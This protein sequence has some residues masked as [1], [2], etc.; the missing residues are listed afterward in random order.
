MCLGSQPRPGVQLNEAPLPPEAV[1]D[2]AS[3]LG[4][5]QDTFIVGGQALNIWAEYYAGSANELNAYRPFTSKDIDYFGY[6]AAA[7]RLA[8]RIG[9]EAIF[10]DPDNT[11]FQTAIVR[12]VIGGVEVEIDFLS[13]VL[14]VGRGLQ[15]GVVD[16]SVPCTRD[17]AAGAIDIRLMHPL[18]CLQS[19]VTNLV[20]L[21]RRDDTARRQAEAAPIVLREFISEALADGDQRAAI[22]IFAGLFTW[23]RSEHEGRVAHRHLKTDPLEIMRHFLEDERLDPRYREFQLSGMI[24]K[25]EKKRGVLGRILDRLSGRS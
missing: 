22:D 5:D 23:L 2:I 15:D 24:H 14:G 16:I 11:T 25:L 1:I 7:E 20:K 6:R 19:R 13:H 10:P 17:G 18:H 12:G 4:E 8:A 9:G 3:I 21:D